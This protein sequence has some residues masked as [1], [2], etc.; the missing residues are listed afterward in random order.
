VLGVARTVQRKNFNSYI[1]NYLT[2]LYFK[3]SKILPSLSYFELV[4]VLGIVGSG[5][6][7]VQRKN[8]EKGNTNVGSEQ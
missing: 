2:S 1:L 8:F 6:G 3:L 4:L 7:T 5:D